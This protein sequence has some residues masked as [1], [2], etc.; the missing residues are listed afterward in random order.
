MVH[1]KVWDEV[2]DEKV[3]ETVLVA[4]KAENRGGDGKTEVR[5]EDQ[6][7]VLLFVERAAGKKVVHTAVA[8]L[9]TDSLAFGLLGVVV[10]TSHVLKQIHRPSSKLLH[11]ERNSSVNW[12]LLHQLVHFVQQSTS[13]SG[14]LLT[15]AWQENHVALHVA[16][17]LVV[18]A[19]TDL[20][21]EI[22]DQQSRMAE[23][24][25]SVIQSLARRERLVSTLV[26]QDPQSSAKQSLEDGVN[27]PQ[28]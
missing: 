20:P 12:G 6:V 1:P 27:S 21:A 5:Q 13:A 4:D 10:V 16:G 18:L 14:V 15:R 24:S 11:Q 8:V 17:S 25:H 22:W 19:V 7:L 9:L 23:P 26:S 3:R 28:R 2:P